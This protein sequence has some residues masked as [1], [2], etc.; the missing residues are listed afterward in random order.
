MRRM[1]EIRGCW[2]LCSK[3]STLTRVGRI[4]LIL[5]I[6]CFVWFLV[7]RFLDGWLRPQT[8]EPWPVYMRWKQPQSERYLTIISGAPPQRL[9]LRMPTFSALQR[10]QCF[11]YTVHSIWH[12][13]SCS[14]FPSAQQWFTPPGRTQSLGLLSPA[15]I[16]YSMGTAPYIP[17]LLSKVI[18]VFL[19]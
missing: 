14:H 9:R 6:N 10:L 17:H 11:I 5:T 15:G 12:S 7:I 16:F 3:L 19:T 4:T 2:M 1:T 13:L 8:E 18:K